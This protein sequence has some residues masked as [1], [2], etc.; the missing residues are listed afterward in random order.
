MLSLIT[1]IS[2]RKRSGVAVTLL[3]EGQVHPSIETGDEILASCL[4]GH[5]DDIYI[6]LC[7]GGVTNAGSNYY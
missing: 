3:A 5:I 4:A 7:F 1:E 2:W 6:F